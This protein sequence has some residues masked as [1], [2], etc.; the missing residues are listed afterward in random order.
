MI[1]DGLFSNPATA[2]NPGEQVENPKGKLDKEAFL[3]LFLEEL[4]TQDP[5]AP[6]ENEKILEQTSM[7]A[8]L[9]SQQLLKDLVEDMSDTFKKDSKLSMQYNSVNMVGK[10]VETGQNSL[11]VD[12]VR[13]SKNFQ[14]YFDEP[15]KSGQIEI[16][17]EGG[18]LIQTIS[19]N[20]HVG[21][22]GY[23]DFS[24]NLQNATGEKV[25]P[26]A[27]S[28]NA[29]YFNEKQQKLETELGRGKVQSVLFEDGQ[30]YLKLGGGYV[31]AASVKEFY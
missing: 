8:E 5:T 31:P 13:D 14:L 4:K 17:D 2:T 10:S 22:S 9:E 15:I 28:V 21:Q 20:D 3:K 19:L 1:T 7:L 30:T 6:M 12:D 25:K 16:K 24:W 11:A 18:S 27:Y 26:G 23:V 29:T